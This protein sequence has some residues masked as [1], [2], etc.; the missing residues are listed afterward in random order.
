MNLCQAI[1]G[2][3]RKAIMTYSC[4]YI[5]LADILLQRQHL[6]PSKDY[7]LADFSTGSLLRSMNNQGRSRFLYEVCAVA[8]HNYRCL[9][10]RAGGYNIEDALK[11]YSPRFTGMGS[12]L[13][14]RS[15]RN[16]FRSGFRKLIVSTCPKANWFMVRTEI[17]ERSEKESLR[18]HC[19]YS[20]KHRL[21]SRRGLK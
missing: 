17:S 6:V 2:C 19:K 8:D 18:C 20:Q 16:Y 3:C 9:A 14:A 15:L 11:Q 4:I 12:V 13:T 7:R 5:P 10:F 1:T 21:K